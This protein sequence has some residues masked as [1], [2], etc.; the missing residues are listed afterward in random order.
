MAEGTHI[1]GKVSTVILYIE[2]IPSTN[3]R[4]LVVAI[5]KK[6]ILD[7]AASH[8]RNEITDVENIL[9]ADHRIIRSLKSIFAKVLIWQ[10]RWEE[11]QKLET[12]VLQWS[13]QKL[14]ERHPDT[15]SS[16]ID[17]AFI[18]SKQKRWKEAGLFQ[19]Q[20]MT[21][22]LSDLGLDHGIT[23]R[24]MS[25]LALTFSSQGKWEEAE[26]LEKHVLQI[27]NGALGSENRDTLHSADVLNAFKEKQDLWKRLEMK[28]IQVTI[29]IS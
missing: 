6:G 18:Q 11:A 3:Q 12:Q 28:A 29:R 16:R 8:I 19:R 25:A 9:G 21:A 20:A 17:L 2:V 24:S 23:L 7:E 27:K 26:R 14:G 22:S 10:E 13:S 5:S 1:L 15:M 4:Y